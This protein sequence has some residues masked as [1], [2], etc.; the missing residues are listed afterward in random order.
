M[1]SLEP[2]TFLQKFKVSLFLIVFIITIISMVITIIDKDLFDFVY[3]L[4]LF[5]SILLVI[6]LACGFFVENVRKK[7]F[8]PNFAVNLIL[9][10]SNI[11]IPFFIYNNSKDEDYR[12]I[13]AFL[14][15]FK[16]IMVFISMA[17][18]IFNMSY[19]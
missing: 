11:V 19:K 17:V 8:C 15:I 7:Y 5:L 2:P 13:F 12:S 14:T 4:Y 3:F 18:F 10:G 16:A 9:W 6:S 1:N